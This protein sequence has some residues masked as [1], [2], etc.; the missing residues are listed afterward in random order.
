MGYIWWFLFYFHACF[1][2]YTMNTYF[3][4]YQNKEVF[5]CFTFKVQEEGNVH[6]CVY[7]CVEAGREAEKGRGAKREVWGE[8]L[9]LSGSLDQSD[10]SVNSSNCHEV[11]GKDC[12]RKTVTCPRLREYWGPGLLKCWRNLHSGVFSSLR[13]QASFPCGRSVHFSQAEK[14]M[15]TNL[16]L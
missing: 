11:L 1:R 12:G 9:T 8:K 7:L 16:H 2:L 15:Q 13:C 3:L 10:Y 4:K 5:L 6:I 14:W